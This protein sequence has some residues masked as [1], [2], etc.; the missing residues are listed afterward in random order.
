MNHLSARSH[1]N[2][3]PQDA[4]D[5]LQVLGRGVKKLVQ[6]VQALR[7][8]GV[9]DLDLPLPKIV[10]VGD[11]STGKSSLIE[12]ISEIKV[13]RSA[14]T[15][16]R[17]PLEINI[18]ESSARWTCTVSLSK[19]YVY[20]GNHGSGR[21]LGKTAT[22]FECATRARPLG[23]WSLQDPEDFH[24]ATFSNKDDVSSILHLAQLATLNPGTSHERYLPGSPHIKGDHQVKFSP[25]VVRLDI[26][27]PGLPNLSLFDLPGVINVSE[28]AEEAYLVDLVKNLV[29]MYIEKENCINLL[30][31]PMSDDLHN[32]S[33]SRLIRENK[34]EFR[35]LGCLTKPDRLQQIEDLEQWVQVLNGQRFQLGYGYHVVMNNPDVNVSHSIAR[36]EECTFFS[37][38]EPW[39]TTL[40]PYAT[41][42][43]TL[44]LQTI[45]SQKLTG[46]IRKR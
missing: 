9:E 35:T 4:E 41:Q 31:L 42:F 43:G 15:C 8:L 7:H 34:V 27:G 5:G 1:P 20:E 23:P 25:N 40:N 33:A 14:G 24:F 17:C 30:A 36:K 21:A 11:Q 6:A 28:I 38:Q 45:L 44:K 26:S 3:E 12:G 39:A 29:K 18:T 37:H 19:K 46:Q 13:P 2:V 32:S 22:K 10:V 16:T